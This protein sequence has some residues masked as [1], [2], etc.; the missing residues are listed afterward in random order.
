MK[1]APRPLRHRHFRFLK[2][3]SSINSLIGST[4]AIFKFRSSGLYCPTEGTATV[5][6]L[7]YLT[8][9]PP[10]SPYLNQKTREKCTNWD[11]LIVPPFVLIVLSHPFVEW[12]WLFYFFFCFTS[13]DIVLIDSFILPFGA[14]CP[15]NWVVT[16]LLSLTFA[17]GA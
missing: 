12:L 16:P 9:E 2:A 11:A 8:Q 15:Q 17:R 1:T 4:N 6:F 5:G 10:A 14:F 3:E 13:A 7:D